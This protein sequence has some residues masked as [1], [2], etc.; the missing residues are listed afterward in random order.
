M[1]A[2]ANSSN[3]RMMINANY[4]FG[5]DETII[6][7]VERVQDGY[8]PITFTFHV[9]ETVPAG[10]EIDVPGSAIPNELAELMLS[11][12]AAYY[13]SADGDVVATNRKLK[14]ELERVTKQLEDL[15]AGIGKL[16]GT[17]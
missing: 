15:I 1:S 16:G 3:Y 14:R 12:F 17:K 10:I 4:R 2:T 7:I 13:L 11:A 8:R 6:K 9:G 5:T